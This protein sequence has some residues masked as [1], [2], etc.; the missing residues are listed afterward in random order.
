M[1]PKN[2]TRFERLHP[3]PAPVTALLSKNLTDRCA[4]GFGV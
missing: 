4:Q 1:E 3:A 2:L